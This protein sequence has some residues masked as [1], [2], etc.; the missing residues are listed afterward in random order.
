LH[1][2]KLLQ[3]VNGEG[4]QRVVIEKPF[5]HDLESA[6]Q[7]SSPL[8]LLDER[9]RR[10]FWGAARLGKSERV[11]SGAWIVKIWLHF[12]DLSS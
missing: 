7:H 10:R 12:A 1:R 4:W 6:R 11:P 8:P 9:A 5:G 2:A 3:K